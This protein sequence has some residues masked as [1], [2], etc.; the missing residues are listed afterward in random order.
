MEKALAPSY[1]PQEMLAELVGFN[2]VSERGNLELI[3]FVAD[4]LGSLGV[5]SSRVFDKTGE[6]AALYAMVGPGIEGG[7]VLSAHTDVVPVENQDW[8]SDPFVLREDGSRLYGRGSADMKGFAATV[9]AHVPKMLDADLKCPIHIAL[10]YDEEVGCLGAPP[11]IADMLKNAPRPT[12]VIV[13]EPTNMKVVNGHK[14]IIVLRTRIFGHPVHSSQLDRGVSAISVAAK[15][16][17]WLD[18]QTAENKARAVP[19]CLFD[20]PYTT[21]HC[22]TIKGGDAHNITAAECEFVTDIRT[23]PDESGA[24]WQARYEAFV[25]DNILP[26]MQAISPDCRIEIE[27]IA[28]VPGLREEQQGLAEQL[29]RQLT[30]DNSRNVVVYATEG[31]QFQDQGVSAIVCGPGSIDQ[32]HQADE[33]IEAAELEKCSAFLDRLCLHLS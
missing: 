10:S 33:Y 15:L 12:A 9:L 1:T 13:G 4:Y 3:D 30:G 2:T 27:R 23:L 5:T 17:S 28:D 24:D 11:M 6:K 32:A 14:G 7:I 22:G 29:A 8:T 26:Q 16:I 31:G 19:N 18:G 21:L 25:S 20:P